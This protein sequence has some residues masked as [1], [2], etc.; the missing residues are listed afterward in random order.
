MSHCC[1]PESHITL[2]TT[3]ATALSSKL[4]LPLYKPMDC[5][6]PGSSV[7]GDSPGPRTLEWGAYPF[8][9]RFPHPGIE[10]GSPAL[11][12]DC[13]PAEP[14]GKP[15]ITYTSIFKTYTEIIYGDSPK[16]PLLATKNTLIP[17]LLHFHDSTLGWH[18]PTY[19]KWVS[20]AR[21]GKVRGDRNG[22]S[23]TKAEDTQ[24]NKTLLQR[25][26]GRAAGKCTKIQNQEQH[27]HP[28]SCP[29][30]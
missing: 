18:P 17:T 26:R 6:V 3:Y 28:E 20:G 1:P 7:H 11:Q 5:S 25:L 23:V 2:N 14:P 4:R 30:C 29:Q 24:G 10:P 27:N 22:A 12:M 9:R 21:K 16:W 15:H 8:S 13:L 19:L